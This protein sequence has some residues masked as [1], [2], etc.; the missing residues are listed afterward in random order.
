MDRVHMWYQTQPVGLWH[1]Q[2][3]RCDCVGTGLVGFNV[4]AKQLGGLADSKQ[5]LETNELQ[6][7]PLCFS[8]FLFFCFV[9]V[10]TLSGWCAADLSE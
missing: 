2:T 6:K 5:L 4:A 3:N 7:E 9:R 8:L 10:H 1:H